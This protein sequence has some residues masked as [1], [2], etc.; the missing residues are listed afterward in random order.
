MIVFR[1]HDQI[2][3]LLVALGLINPNYGNLDSGSEHNRAIDV[4][5]VSSRSFDI[6]VI[7]E[8]SNGLDSESL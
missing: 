2:G 3:V 5:D 1:F 8:V 6:V 7:D 4:P